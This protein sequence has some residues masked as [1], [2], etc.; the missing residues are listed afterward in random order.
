MPSYRS[1]YK[2]RP[3]SVFIACAII[4]MAGLAPAMAINANQ[5][6]CG[7]RWRVIMTPH[8]KVIYPE[9]IEKDAQRVAATL[10]H[11]Y[12]H[13]TKTLKFHP[14]RLSVLLYNQSVESNGMAAYMPRRSQWWNT[15]PQGSFAGTNDWYTELAIHEFRHIVQMDSLNRGFN[16]ALYVIFGEQAAFVMGALSVPWWFIEGDAVGTETAL[17]SSGRGRIPEFDVELRALLLSGKRY[18]YF[19]ALFG[20]YRDWDPLKSPY[21]LGYYM[22]THV[23]RKYGPDVWADMMYRA[24][25]APFVPHWFDFMLI[26]K[27]GSSAYSLYKD[28]MDEMERLWKEQLDG[29]SF[30]D[31][32]PLHKTD[33]RYWT[34]NNAPQYAPD[35]SVITL[36]YGMKGIYSLMR[37]D[38]ATGKESRLCY[39]GQINFTAPSVAG[40]RVAWSEQVPDIRWGQRSYS[41][42]VTYDLKTRKKRT[43]ANN[44]RLFAPALSPDG[45]K[46]AAVEY[47]ST[48]ECSLVLIDAD[49]GAELNR[50]AA[51]EREFIQTPHWSLDGKSIVFTKINRL[52]GKAIA[53]VNSDTGLSA[54]IVPYTAQNLYYPVSDGRFIYFVSPHSG[55]DNIYAVNIA[56]K[57]I[58]QVTS[59]KFGAYYPSLS[60]DGKKL[61]FN[62]V[63]AEGY[64][65]VEMDLDPAKWVPI[66]KVRDRSVQYYEPLIAQEAGGDITKD[67]PE[68]AYESKKF[69]HF[70]HLFYIYSWMPMADPFSENLT[71][72]VSSR[73][74]LGTTEIAAGYNYN[75]NEKT[76]AGI[77]SVSYGGLYPVIDVSLFYGTRASTYDT[78]FYYGAIR[79]TYHYTWRE[80]RPSLGVKVPLDLSRSRFTTLLTLGARGSY[81]QAY[82]MQLLP[83]YYTANR[84][85][86][87]GFVPISYF[88]SFYNG[89]KWFADLYPVWGQSIDIVYRH[90]PFRGHTKGSLLSVSGTFYFPGVLPHHSLF[91]Q[92]AYEL[93]AP[94]DYQFASEILFAR[95]YDYEFSRHTAKAG[96]NYTF[97]IFNPDWNLV[98]VLHF[99]RFF[100]N[101]FGDYAVSM[102]E[103]GKKLRVKEYYRSAGMELCAEMH[104]F[105]IEVPFVLG[106]RGYYRF[107]QHDVYV[108]PYGFEFIFG[109]G[110]D[111]QNVFKTRAYF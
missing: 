44:T 104:F 106:V 89:Y 45:K 21:L 110:M 71:L 55:I 26:K 4:L 3:L 70:T 41:V 78:S 109:I 84:Y 52:K 74:L 86:N 63:T 15:P 91:L 102:A 73:N 38:P 7:L 20:S 51:E 94:R 66:E 43:L 105:S 81:I 46:I 33:P 54:T 58:F 37:I 49:T 108:R 32:R 42:I 9:E 57:K 50:Y 82:D 93:Q 62:D 36:R 99:K 23:K 100:A 39:P 80:L 19:K 95:G 65:A 98:H 30:T 72:T 67:I 75:W 48:N 59:R 6:P 8:F 29:L 92:G 61:A 12:P 22:T 34:Y 2:Y 5:N 101:L 17:T 56:T 10:E 1:R 16:K 111:I 25:W 88:A 13:V 76:H 97:P 107:D 83:R 14:K 69:N 85:H 40:G 28:T 53:I 60:P 87:G 11:A 96:L 31:A 64:T 47:T 79:E 90:T 24:T 103:K 68:G 77:L 18:K 35:G 27:T